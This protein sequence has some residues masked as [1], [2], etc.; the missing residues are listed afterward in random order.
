[1]FRGSVWFK[2]HQI[3]NFLN[4][5]EWTNQCLCKDAECFNCLDICMGLE[6][7]TSPLNVSRIFCTLQKDPVSKMF[8]KLYLLS[9]CHIVV[10]SVPFIVEAMLLR[11]RWLCLLLI[12]NSDKHWGK[13]V[14]VL[15]YP[16]SGNYEH[17]SVKF[18]I[19]FPWMSWIRCLNACF[20]NLKSHDFLDL[21]FMPCFAKFICRTDAMR[22]LSTR[23]LPSSSSL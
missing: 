5:P 11:S 17:A 1:M 7:W 20:W 12:D 13:L 9:Y 3:L 6:N 23:S 15:P 8:K 16:C 2:Q 19:L 18:F 22:H 21:C 14:F 4:T 10:E